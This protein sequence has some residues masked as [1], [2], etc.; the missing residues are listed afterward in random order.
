MGWHLLL[1]LAD[2]LGHGRCTPA[3]L[4]APRV[5]PLR[6]V[7]LLTSIQLRVRCTLLLHVRGKCMKLVNATSRGLLQKMMTY[8]IGCLHLIASLGT[9]WSSYR[10]AVLGKRQQ[11]LNR[12]A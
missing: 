8:L 4:L 1:F 12:E 3:C 11:C 7:R 10:P 9:Q 5:E 6:N 2:H